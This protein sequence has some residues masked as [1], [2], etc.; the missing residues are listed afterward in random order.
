[1]VI[2]L[3]GSTTPFPT[4]IA[5]Y[6]ETAG[7]E[8]I[9][10]GRDTLDYYSPAQMETAFKEYP[11]P[12][13][14]V[15]NQRVAGARYPTAVSPMD[16]DYLDSIEQFARINNNSLHGSVWSKV[17]IH[18]IL[19]KCKQFVFITSSITLN[20]TDIDMGFS[21]LSYRYLRASE[22]Q[23]MKCISIEPNKTAYG[24]CPGGMDLDPELWAEGTAKIINGELSDD[25]YADMNGEVTLVSHLLKDIFYQA[26]RRTILQ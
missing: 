6:L 3:I 12:D 24:L 2:Y 15:F 22:Q 8:V 1:M 23:L 18:Q 5:N 26:M 25:Q 7:H 14:V 17:V 21:R 16:P 20:N 4:T 19:N 11:A 9:K 13:I 10:L